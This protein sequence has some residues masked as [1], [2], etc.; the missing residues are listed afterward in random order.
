MNRQT[1]DQ[2]L[3]AVQLAGDAEHDP[4]VSTEPPHCPRDFQKRALVGKTLQIPPLCL[5]LASRM[6][7]SP[8]GA[9]L[10]NELMP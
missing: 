1:L 2:S 3:T 7:A 8:Q 4:C 10:L 6:Q 5:V 9:P